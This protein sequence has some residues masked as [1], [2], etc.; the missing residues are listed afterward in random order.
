[1]PPFAASGSYGFL[2]SLNI[3]CLLPDSVTWTVPKQYRPPSAALV[4]DRIIPSASEG[5][6]VAISLLLYWNF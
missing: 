5:L 6:G 1:M 2:L 3:G 4:I